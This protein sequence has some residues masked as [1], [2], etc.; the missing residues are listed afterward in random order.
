MDY[1]TG[2]SAQTINLI[3]FP[4]SIRTKIQEIE[5]ELRSKNKRI[6]PIIISVDSILDITTNFTFHN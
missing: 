2:K 5:R 4:N 3:P 6:S 1:T